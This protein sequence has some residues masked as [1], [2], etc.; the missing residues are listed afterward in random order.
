MAQ[1]YMRRWVPGIKNHEH[2]LFVLG[3]LP[4]LTQ[5]SPQACE[6]VRKWVA[7]TH[8][9]SISTMHLLES[10]LSMWSSEN[11]I[12]CSAVVD[13]SNVHTFLLKLNSYGLLC[14]CVCISCR[15]SVFIRL[16][17]FIP[18]SYSLCEYHSNIADQTEH[19]WSACMVITVPFH[20]LQ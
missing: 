6:H 9:I 10:L 18:A 8:L 3:E 14:V 16:G 11:Y 19:R 20:L 2:E 4:L 5:P 1:V 7:Y 13:N 17:T 15:D 12:V